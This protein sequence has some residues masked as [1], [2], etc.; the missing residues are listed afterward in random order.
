MDNKEKRSE[1]GFREATRRAKAV[2][3]EKRKKLA[4]AKDDE[5]ARAFKR[6]Q[7]RRNGEKF[8]D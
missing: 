3:Q 1:H 5:R 4:E 7:A 2:A 8:D 6:E